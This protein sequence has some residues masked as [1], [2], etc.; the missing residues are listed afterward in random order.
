[1]TT[2]PK[3]LRVAVIGCGRIAVKHLSSIKKSSYA[4][5]VAC[6]DLRADRAKA[7][8][9]EYGAA[10]YTD[11]REMLDREKP[12]AVHICLPHYLHTAVACEAFERGIHVLCEKPM[13]VD[14]QTARRATEIAEEKGI[15][16]GIVFQCRYNETSKFI[17]ET[18]R[19]GRLGKILSVSSVLT[20]A[21]DDDYYTSSD[22]KGTWDK[23]GGGVIIDQAIHSID[24]VN[25]IVDSEV[26]D[27]SAM[28]AT[29]GHRSIQV[30][31]TACGLITYANGVKYG[32]YCMNNFCCNEPIEIK[33]I[34]EKGKAIL[35]YDFAEVLYEDG[36][37]KKLDLTAQMDRSLGD[38]SYWGKSHT[39]QI[40]QF[41]RAVLGLEPLQISAREALKTHSIICQIYEKAGIK[42]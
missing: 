22:W 29:Q 33:F 8:A 7:C 10:A 9:E 11:F 12:D 15:L 17:Y 26:T 34:C 27:I 23:E 30:E 3:K 1:M 5:L 21:R 40:D 36:T 31:D 41:Y 42:K 32:F 19:S 4:V 16:Y 18:V 28:V 25:W 13:D 35:S 24:L 37:G 39:V 38:K 6:C 20:W 2:N 14:F